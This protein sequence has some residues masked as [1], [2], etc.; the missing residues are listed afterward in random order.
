M[1]DIRQVTGLLFDQHGDR[2]EGSVRF[3]AQ[4]NDAD[5][6][7][8]GNDEFRH[9]TL[10]VGNSKILRRIVKEKSYS[11]WPENLCP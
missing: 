10:S 5:L 1:T 8:A 7:A 9:S 2:R 4:A 6:A 11:P 3:G